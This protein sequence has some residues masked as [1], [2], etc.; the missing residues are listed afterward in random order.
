MRLDD[1]DGTEDKGDDGVGLVCVTGRCAP[2]RDDSAAGVCNR[3]LAGR[4]WLGGEGARAALAGSRIVKADDTLRANLRSLSLLLRIGWPCWI[5]VPPV[6]LPAAG[7]CC[8]VRRRTLRVDAGSTAGAMFSAS[9]S[10]A[11]LLLPV[12]V[13]EWRGEVVEL[14][15]G[16]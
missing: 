16:S 3:R 15:D 12:D 8:S 4:G 14:A 11:R 7:A 6:E 9:S 10:L 1:D 2:V 13:E 5:V